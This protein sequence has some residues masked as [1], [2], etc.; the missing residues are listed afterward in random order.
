MANAKRPSERRQAPRVA[1]NFP[2]KLAWGKKKYTAQAQEFSEFGIFLQCE[3]KELV[4]E[5]V[6]LNIRFDSRTSAIALEGMVAYA[7]DRGLG[8]RFKKL[9]K[10]Q[11]AMLRER[12]KTTSGALQPAKIDK[13]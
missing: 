11:E 2:V 3:S 12:V 4:G 8:V 1:V 5:N 6:Q 7:N 9:T 13:R 10:E